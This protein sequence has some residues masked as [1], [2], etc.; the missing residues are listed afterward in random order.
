MFLAMAWSTQGHRF[1][2]IFEAVNKMP[3]QFLAPP[4]TTVFVWGV[5]WRRGTKQAALTTL[6]MGF[7]LGIVAFLVDLPAFGEVQW[8]T[9]KE[10]GLGISFMMQAWWGFC[11]CS[12]IYVATSLLTPK[13]DPESLTTLT[14]PHPF[15]VIFHGKITRWY[16]PRLLAG[17]LF[18]LMVVLYYLFR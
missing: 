2:T 18:G 15:K 8:I 10:Q 11:L 5:F 3:A 1:D 13:P 7:S 14:W 12:L 17:L 4:I 9:D 16:D 6:I